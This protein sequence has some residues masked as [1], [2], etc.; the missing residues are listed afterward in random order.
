MVDHEALYDLGGLAA[1]L[2]H[3]LEDWP[4]RP[5]SRYRRVLPSRRG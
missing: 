3:S 4:A 1:D 5:R 2:H